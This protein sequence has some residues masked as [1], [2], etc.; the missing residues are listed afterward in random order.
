LSDPDHHRSHHPEITPPWSRSDRPLPRRVVRPLQEFLSTSTASGAM[1]LAAAV[2][3]LLWANS[4][5]GDSYE[6]FWGTSV[7]VRLGRWAIREDLR[8]WVNDGLMSL[9]FLVVGLEI[10]REFLVGEMR[11]I[12]A[13]AL[14][15]VGAIGGMVVPALLYLAF[16][17]GGSGASGWGIPM[18]TDIAFALGVLVLAARHAPRGLKPFVLT[19]AIVD[20]I[21]AIIVIAVF[22]AG[23]VSLGFLLGAAALCLAMVGL[24]RIGV[25]SAYVFVGLGAL[26]WLA[27]NSSGVHP[28]IA[29][30]VLGLLAPADAQQR[31]DAVSAEA[32]RTAD[33][34]VDEPVPPDADARH[35][36]WLATLS[37]EAVS[38]LARTEH[39]LLPWTS[40]GIVPLFALANAGVRLS[41]EGIADAVTS[42]VT[43]GVAIGL[44]VGKLA[45]IS[46]AAGLALRTGVGRLPAGVHFSHLA[47]AAAV[48]G[49]GFTVSLFIAALAFD[50]RALVDQAKV[51]ILIASVLAGTAGWLLLRAAPAVADTSDEDE[52]EAEMARS[53]SPRRH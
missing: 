39:A 34:T 40:F 52:G 19:L 26:V 32:R 27:T 45:G 5:W 18:A 20:D 48:A 12:R 28:T 3:A 21:G 4:P 38:P 47:G 49:I 50:D 43:L 31:P 1:L 2:L 42:P 6:T 14:P 22:Y 11:G 23:G 30:V 29:G 46:A 7:E 13:A 33:L 25:R 24:R 8:H 15:V 51:G 41:S 17:A 37:R 36:L 10:K 53:L 16:N 9:F 44:V 35:W